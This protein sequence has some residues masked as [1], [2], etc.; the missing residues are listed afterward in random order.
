MSSADDDRVVVR[1]LNATAFKPSRLPPTFLNRT[2]LS[3]ALSQSPDN[4][5]TL[6]LAH[7]GLTDIG[8]SAAEELAFLGRQDD[9]APGESLLLRCVIV[10]LKLISIL[11][12]LFSSD[13]VLLFLA[14][15]ACL[16]LQSLDHTSNG[17]RDIITSTIFESKKQSNCRVS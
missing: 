10:S 15:Q 11:I 14:M 8:E 3:D 4:G 1:P 12:I 5:A 17:I 16:E 7:K 13:D 2:H 9:S 6:D